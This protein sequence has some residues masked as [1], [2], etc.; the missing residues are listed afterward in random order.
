MKQR[1]QRGYTLI[2]ILVALAIVAVVIGTSIPIIGS[3]RES[4]QLQE[5]AQKLYTLVHE[6]RSRSFNENQRLLIVLQKDGFS[7]Y[8]NNDEKP[9]QKISLPEDMS[10]FIKPWL[11]RDWIPPAD[12]EW[13]I[14]PFELSEPLSFRFERGDQY[15][16]QTYHPL[17]AQ[18]IDESLYIP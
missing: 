14:T 13:R 10:Y 18:V 5:P 6:A 8:S 11:A 15:L 12:Y 7:L 2:E 9:L 1:C 4:A 3:I 17:T 16:E